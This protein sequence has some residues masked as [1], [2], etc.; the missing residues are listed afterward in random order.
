MNTIN[1]ASNLPPRS[2]GRHPAP[3]PGMV[4]IVFTVLFLASL[5]PVTLLF[6]KMHS[7]SPNQSS[8]EIIAYFLSGTE[9]IKIRICAFLQFGSAIPLGISAN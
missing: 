4:A 2:G 3:N 7:P 6:S 8:E 9:T 5:V 1:P